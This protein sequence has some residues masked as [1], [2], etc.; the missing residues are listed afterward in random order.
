MASE[1]SVAQAA[2]RIAQPLLEERGYE[3][4]DAEYV[5]QGKEWYLNIYIYKDGGVDLDDCEAI[6]LLLDPLMDAD[7]VIAGKP[8]FFCVS[9]PGLD[10][11]FK[12]TRDFLRC[13]NQKIEVRLFAPQDGKKEFEGVLTAADDETIE[14]QVRSRTIT[15]A[16]SAIALARPAVSFESEDK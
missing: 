10:R 7:P 16:R 11:P 12:K 3:L 14:M 9:S 1:L 4:V 13:L 6:S 2:A 8:D 15:L 5:K